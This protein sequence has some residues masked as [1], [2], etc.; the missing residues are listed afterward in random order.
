IKHSLP[1]LNILVIII[2]LSTLNHKTM[3][4]RQKQLTEHINVLKQE[5]NR[6]K[7]TTDK[8]KRDQMF[9]QA[10]EEIDALSPQLQD[11]LDHL[12]NNHPWIKKD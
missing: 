5:I 3:N 11:Q 12:I 8:P 6:A 1:N 2:M 7:E 4:L 9:Q 10:L